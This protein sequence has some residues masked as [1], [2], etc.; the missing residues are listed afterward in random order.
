MR[1]MRTVFLDPEFLTMGD[2]TKL[3][4]KVARNEV[5]AFLAYPA[6]IPALE[7]VKSK[8]GGGCARACAAHSAK[9]S[10]CAD[11]GDSR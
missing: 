8:R 6:K 4:E 5:G 1:S 3:Y 7:C 2:E 11:D 9:R 10:V